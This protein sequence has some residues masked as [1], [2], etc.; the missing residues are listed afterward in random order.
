MRPSRIG[1]RLDIYQVTRLP[2]WIQDWWA[3]PVTF[4]DFVEWS[5]V[6]WMAWR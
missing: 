4:E 6:E 2:R 1:D 3:V 5:G